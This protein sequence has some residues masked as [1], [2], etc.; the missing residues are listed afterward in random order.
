MSDAEGERWFS[1]AVE[2]ADALG[3]TR[4]PVGPGRDVD[5]WTDD[6]LRRRIARRV[7]LGSESSIGSMLVRALGAYA[8][9]VRVHIRYR[10]PRGRRFHLALP[11]DVYTDIRGPK[12]QPWHRAKR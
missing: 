1:W 3:W 10:R 7:L 2:L 12:L 9:R 8:R 5:A 11:D 6:E 4:G